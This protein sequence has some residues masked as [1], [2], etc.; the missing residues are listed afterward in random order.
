M[1][2]HPLVSIITPCYNGEN[3]V[4]RFFDSILAQTYRNIELIFVNDGS[5]DKTEERALSYKEKFES[6]GIHFVYIFQENKGLAGAIN[7]GLLKVTGKY[8]CWPDSDDYLE[9]TSIEK[10]VSILEEFTDYAVV[11]SDAYIRDVECLELPIGLISNKD[12]KKYLTNQFELLLIGES[13]FCSG[14]H[15][16]RTNSFFDTHPNGRF[17]PARRGQNWQILLPIYYKYKRYFLDE[18][19]YNYVR[20]PQT[21]SKGDNTAEKKLYRCDEHVEILLNTINTID[22]PLA[23]KRRYEDIV[24][25]IYTRKRLKIAYEYGDRNLLKAQYKL[26]AAHKQLKLIDVIIY[27]GGRYRCIGYMIGYAGAIKKIVRRTHVANNQ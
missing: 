10:R 7:T 4:H 20:Y 26:L 22:M 15:M 1:I 3:Y 21:M 12:P 18:P 9:A 2:D 16:I 19:L 17:F 14:C 5:T 11:T 8:L 13:I 6:N 27:L 24:N 25:T 23:E